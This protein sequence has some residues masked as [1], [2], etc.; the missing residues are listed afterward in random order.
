MK[1]IS[2]R[3]RQACAASTLV[4]LAMSGASS[5]ET[6]RDTLISAYNNSRLIE[7]NRAVL[8]AA[9]EDVAVAVSALRPVFSYSASRSYSWDL[10][11]GVNQVTGIRQDSQSITNTLEMTGSWALFEFGRNK[12]S[13][14]AA[15]EAVLAAR[16]SLISVEQ[17]VLFQ[18][19]QAYTEM[20]RSQDFVALRR[21]N[22]RVLNE[23]VRAAND[24]FEVGEVTRTDVAQAEARLAESEANLVSA[25]GDLE[26]ARE[27]FNLAVGRYPGTL[28]PPP[29]FPTIPAS[30][31]EARQIALASHP[32]IR[33]AQYL[34]SA[35]ELNVQVAEREI[36][37][38]LQVTGS[39]GY[40]DRSS[41]TNDLEPDASLGIEFGGPIYQGGRLNALY[42]QSVAQRDQ[43]RA[44]LLQTSLTISERVG[45]AWANLQVARASLRATDRA[46]EANQV[47]FDG[48]REEATLGARTTLDVL[49]AEQELLDSRG[50]R[51][52]A[53]T[54][55]QDAYYFL[56][57]TMGLLTAERLGLDVVAYDP[58]AYYNSV[59]NAPPIGASE[60][61]IKLDRVLQSLGKK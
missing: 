12:L 51:L 50:D 57:S 1:S 35:S 45:F 54:V 16:Q 38:A 48:T 32:D 13:V 17:T 59:R 6:L 30:V 5:A 44:N 26:T 11:T 20:R 3:L 28:A 61:G 56:L 10:E 58:E 18:A 29:A 33:Q 9:D 27:A 49:N 23:E 39:V 14:E 7:Q 41:L 19:V 55:E 36:L 40:S 43:N 25:Q 53:L 52:D 22:V 47:A 34:V 2:A 24:R 46:I 42:R 31:D 15:K 37:P 4:L 60:E 21:N 8:R